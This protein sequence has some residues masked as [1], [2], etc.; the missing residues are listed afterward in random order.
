MTSTTSHVL[1]QR[2][3]ILTTMLVSLTLMLA[4]CGG[5]T[6]TSPEMMEEEVEEMMDEP[7]MGSSMDESA[8]VTLNAS[9]SGSA[10]ADENGS[11][12]ATVMIDAEAGEVCYEIEV[13]DIEDPTVAHIHM[14]AAGETGGVAVDFNIPENGM[15]GCVTGIDSDQANEII[16][17]PENFYVNVHNDP[18]PGGAIR[19]Q[20]MRH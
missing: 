2:G 11:G 16:D 1:W 5:D 17:S 15:D 6:D 9:L 20:L 19:G 7:S 12:T 8:S 14:G 18:F 4:A 3:T 13:S 10:N